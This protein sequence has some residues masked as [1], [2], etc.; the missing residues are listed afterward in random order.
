MSWK[1]DHSA[2]GEI[3]IDGTQTAEVT[4]LA[5]KTGHGARF[6]GNPR[7]LVL[8]NASKWDSAREALNK[9]EAE[10]VVQLERT[11]DS[12]EVERGVD[13]TTAIDMT[14]E[15]RHRFFVE[16]MLD[17]LTSSPGVNVKAFGA[18]GDGVADDTDAVHNAFTFA[19]DGGVVF[20]PAGTYL[21]STWPNA[22]RIYAKKVAIVGEG[23]ASKI[24]GPNTALFLDVAQALYVHGCVFQDWLKVFELDEVVSAI[25]SI[26]IEACALQ[27]VDR[28]LS[29]TVPQV[30][31]E[32]DSFI[33]R[34]CR[35]D[36]LTEKAIWMYGVWNHLHVDS[37][38]V[39]VAVDGGFILGRDTAADEAD[40]RNTKVTN[41]T[42]KALTA[43]AS[44]VN[45]R[46][47][48]IYGRD[49][50][51]TGNTIEDVSVSGGTTE[52][53]GIHC[54]TQRAVIS[55]NSVFDVDGFEGLRGIGIQ[56]QG[57]DRGGAESSS[58]AGYKAVIT[59]NVVDMGGALRSR[60]IYVANEDVLCANNLIMG[61]QDHGIT[62]DTVGTR[63]HSNLL[64]QGNRID[65]DGLGTPGT[66]INVTASGSNIHILNNVVTG[67]TRAVVLQPSAGSPTDFAILGNSLGAGTTGIRIVPTV[68]ITGL[69]IVG[70]HIFGATTGISFETTAPDNVQLAWNTF[71]G[72]TTDVS[73]SV[74]PT[75]LNRVE[76]LGGILEIHGETHVK[77]GGLT[78]TGG[79]TI[80]NTGLD[81]TGG[82]ALQNLQ[83]IMPT[84]V[85]IYDGAG[86]PGT[87]LG[88]Q[89]S[90][91]L[92]T[93]GGVGST[94]YYKSAA[95]TWTAVA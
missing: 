7:K 63:T 83:I 50:V 44:G 66:G 68:T 15:T 91:F 12:L 43:S 55:G 5:L 60:G 33:I 58:P 29:W 72:A 37:C 27:S 81:V 31:G 39:D 64:I 38:R 8:W 94:L 71:R 30:G 86:V 20:F 40:W 82:I 65:L 18:V 19:D 88:A 51:I 53:V 47:I 73:F 75:N 95:S 36:N 28:G 14:L 89:G 93:D 52:A 32:V 56:Q 70:N 76:Q 80:V 11:G 17:I 26:H 92:R 35:F 84:G 13:G 23:M 34:N 59:G 6:A 2:R 3:D 10:I 48:E 62:T 21:L 57:D 42:I 78:V 45:V 67:A 90:I 61:V 16:N 87:G 46:A 77:T 49:A 74:T 4:T 79:I 9:G 25:E 22:G 24:Q 41:C 85:G 69:K 1:Y 54:M